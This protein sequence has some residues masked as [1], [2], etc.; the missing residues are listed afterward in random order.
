MEL[1]H[2]AD[3]GGDELTMLS[4]NGRKYPNFP[5]CME[6]KV[7]ET[8]PSAA[9]CSD[10]I[11]VCTFP[12]SGT[13]WVY[14]MVCLLAAGQLEPD[15]VAKGFNLMENCK[16]DDY[17][18][19]VPSPRILN[20]HVRF[21]ELPE[22]VKVNKPRILYVT[23]NPKDVTVS[24]YNHV[25]KI[26]KVYTYN[27]EWKNFVRPS[28]E[29]KFEYGSWFDYVKD[30]EEVKKTTDVPILTINYE[31]MQENVFREMKKVAAFLGINRSDEFVKEVC[32]HCS[33][34][35]MQKSRSPFAKVMYRKGEVG[36][37]K[38]WFTVAQN[39]WCDHLF[40]EK[41]KDCPLEFR[42]SLK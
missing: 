16:V 30:W 1:I 31:D 14:E 34:A 8:L 26:S 10:D 23:R 9:I 4:Y 5:G 20:T 11:L 38:N 33:F 22:Q 6:K 19:D 17:Y 36:D 2:V 37:W 7:L 42:Y 24:Y 28:L 12:K 18:K 40:K 32:D 41:M 21:N 35:S 29:G 39:E 27:G 25:K 15:E 13:H 3:D